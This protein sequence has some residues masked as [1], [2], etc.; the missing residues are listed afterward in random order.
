MVDDQIV[1]VKG[2][3]VLVRP[4]RRVNAQ[5]VKEIDIWVRTRGVRGIGAL[6]MEYAEEEPEF[7]GWLMKQLVQQRLTTDVDPVSEAL[8]LARIAA[9]GG[10]EES[11]GGSGHTTINVVTP[12]LLPSPGL[13]M[14]LAI[15][16][17]GTTVQQASS[18]TQAARAEDVVYEDL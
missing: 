3:T 1:P 5:M 16:V 6:I 7:K 18:D 8:E 17:E 14:P 4:K 13:R 2:R 12:A 11:G 9:E 15:E 10:R